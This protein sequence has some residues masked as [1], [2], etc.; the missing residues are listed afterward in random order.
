[1]GPSDNRCIDHLSVQGERTS[2]LSATA[3]SAA[4]TRRAHSSS[5]ALGEK[6][7]LNIATCVGWVA[8]A[9]AKPTRPRTRRG[10]TKLMSIREL[11]DA[12]NKLRG[13]ANRGAEVF[14]TKR[15]CDHPWVRLASAR[16]PG[17]RSGAR[18]RCLPSGRFL[19]P[20]RSETAFAISDTHSAESVFGRQVRQHLPLRLHRDRPP[21]TQ[22]KG[23][24]ALA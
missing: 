15:H 11:A 1:M 5:C 13:A 4:R 24:A 6:A 22:V 2:A 7:S 17:S 18:N 3:F 19:S 9:P 14:R 23:A 8:K 20:S 21:S 12:S 10:F 16:R